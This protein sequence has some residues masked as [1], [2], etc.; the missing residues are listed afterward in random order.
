MTTFRDL[1]A[2]TKAEIREVDTAT[3]AELRTQAGTVVLDV[4]EPD[5]H[6]QGAIPGSVFVPRGQLESQVENLIPDKSATVVIHCA[7]G[8]RSAFAAKT[9]AEL[10]YTD[11][12]SMAGGFN[13]WKDEGR[14]WKAPRTLTAEQRNRYHRH[15]LL[16]EVGTE[17]QQKLLDAKVLL[18]STSPLRG[19]AA[20]ASSTW[21]SSTTRT[22]SGRSSTTSSGWGSARST[23]PRRRS[24]C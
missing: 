12:A 10:G 7:S 20:S 9:L 15:L 16:P 17:G 21:T 22:S 23:R 1:L 8:V 19:S 18:R 11:V 6:A 14:E 13:Q 3:A 5:E 4:R 24:R 2:A